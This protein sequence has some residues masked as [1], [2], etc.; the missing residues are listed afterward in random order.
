MSKRTRRRRR[1]PRHGQA[2]EAG[3]QLRSVRMLYRDAAG[4]VST[5]P[6]SEALAEVLAQRGPTVWVDLDSPPPD[7]S[8]QVLRH[9]FQLH[10]LLVE[11]ILHEAHIPKIN[12]YGDVL[13]IVLHGVKFHREDQALDT[14]EVDMILGRNFLITF[15]IEPVA[16]LEQLWK[17]CLRDGRPLEGGAD[18]LAYALID[19]LVSGFPLAIDELDEA[20]D[21]IEDE[22]FS[23][24][25]PHTLDRIFTL[26]RAA[27]HV[28]RIIAPQ[29][30]VANRL[31][32]DT[33]T[34]I[35][36]KDRMY[37]R[38]IYDQLVRIY[39]LNESLRDLAAG[40]LDTY[41]S[42]TS[43]RIN[44]VMKFLTVF[45]ALFMPIAFLAGFF[46]MNFTMIPWDS[47]WLLAATIAVMLVAPVGFLA[48]FRRSGW[49]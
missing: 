8:E 27:L 47:P 6:S 24:P 12:D 13:Q 21:Q 28:R 35:D 41:L 20:V 31:A 46:G 49:L 3:V 1:K 22:V 34:L 43:Y 16:A 30:E 36:D 11:D 17:A 33:Y 40:A 15:H 29:R 42:V 10:P 14:D 26:K 9:V 37:F 38:N 23:N 19:E 7:E 39:D 48:Y 2:P 45:T 44:E 18:H 32:R 4:R 5:I 25:T